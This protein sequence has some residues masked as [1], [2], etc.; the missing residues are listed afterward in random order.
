LKAQ[1]DERKAIALL[2]VAL[3]HPT[4]RQQTKD[5]MVALAMALKPHF[6]EKETVQGFEWAK[7]ASIEDMATSWVASISPKAKNKKK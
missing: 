3:S 6:S 2:M 1:G 4:C 7:A 5:R